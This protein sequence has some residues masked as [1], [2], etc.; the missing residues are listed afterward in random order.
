MSVEASMK[1]EA[2]SVF[3][4]VG[5]TVARATELVQLEVQLARAEIGEKAVHVRAGL[6]LMG[7]GGIVLT[8]ALFVLVQSLV[9]ALVEAGLS[10]L[11]ATFIVAAALV[12]VGMA[13]V[14]AGRKQFDANVLTPH[15]TLNDLKRDGAIVKEKLS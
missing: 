7:A 14:A 10:P 2:P 1:P 8:A 11:A 12:A 13:L 3:H 4:A 6:A 15:R 5:E 9:V